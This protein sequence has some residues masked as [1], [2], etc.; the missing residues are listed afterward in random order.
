M[1]FFKTV[2]GKVVGGIVALIV[3][4]AA[5][6]WLRMSSDTRGALVLGTGK[7]VAWVLTVVLLPWA[8]FF[9]I[10]WVATFRSNLAGGVLV[11]IISALELVL[12]LWMFDWHPGG[13]TAWTFVGVGTLVAAVYNLFV[14]DWLAE[15]FE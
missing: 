9:V 4:I 12:L 5:I 3:L 7:I 2:A 14:S 1:D 6:S 15:R 8:S 11:A 10:G 13:T